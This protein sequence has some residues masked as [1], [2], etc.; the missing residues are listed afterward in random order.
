[1]IKIKVI[2]W[3]EKTRDGVTESN[4][5]ILLKILINNT[6]VNALPRGIDSYR[7]F[8]RLGKAFTESEKTGF[9]ELLEADYS[10]LKGIVEKDIVGPWG[11]NE[12]ILEAVEEFLNAKQVKK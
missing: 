12:K 6:D 8:G 5:A 1:M 10:Q 4:T 11:M 9:I 3:S 2:K 7:F